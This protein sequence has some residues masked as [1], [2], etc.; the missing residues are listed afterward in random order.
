MSIKNIKLDDRIRY[1]A[2]HK[3]DTD[4]A[5]YARLIQS[6]W[7]EEKGYKIGSYIVKTKDIE[8]GNYIKKEIAFKDGCNF[9]TQTIRDV[10]KQAIE[11]KESGA[12]IEKNRLYTNLLSSQPLA[13]NL[14]A[15]LKINRD[16]A[17]AFFANQFP[18]KVETVIDILFEHSE[19]RG[20]I[21]YTGDHS[22]FDV[23]VKF[24][25]RRGGIGFIAIE[26]KYA[27]NMA[28]TPATHK[29]RYEELSR[30][31]GIFYEN[32]DALKRKH[33][34]QI[35]RD[36][37]LSIAHVKESNQKYTEGIFV[38]LYPSENEQCQNAVNKYR[39]QLVSDKEDETGFCPR[40]LEDYIA[41][42][43]DITNDK[44]IKDLRERY[45]REI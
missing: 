42:I 33:I 37:L 30:N 9:L 2:Y 17:T 31:S 11:H 15:E 34:Q 27:E 35:W 10:V 26:V 12:K 45:F 7:R 16:L 19:G 44:W 43:M 4:F 32:I 20:K 23:F 28:D 40:L 38:F 3:S 5:A 18:E 24:K 36:H 22:A 21:E 41:A 25:H 8:L 29:I 1:K 13:F 39:A 6:I 14:F